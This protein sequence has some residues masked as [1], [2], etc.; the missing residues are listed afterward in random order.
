MQMRRRT[1]TTRRVLLK[2]TQRHT[3]RK[4]GR[5]TGTKR[6]RNRKKRRILASRARNPLQ[7]SICSRSATSCKQCKPRLQL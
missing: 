3:R 4:T 2:R 7:V 1:M 5:K 6:G